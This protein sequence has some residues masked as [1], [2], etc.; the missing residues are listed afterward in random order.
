M[1]GVTAGTLSQRSLFDDSNPLH[2]FG[3]ACQRVLEV[4]LKAGEGL[5]DENLDEFR[6]I[7][8]RNHSSV[9]TS[10]YPID[11]EKVSVLALRLLQL[12]RPQ[13]P[14]SMPAD[15]VYGFLT[16]EDLRSD[17]CRR[18]F[19]IGS[20]SNEYSPDA[21]YIQ[22]SSS[23]VSGTRLPGFSDF[24]H[25]FLTQYAVIRGLNGIPLEELDGI[26]R[27]CIENN[28]VIP[29]R[30]WA[31]RLFKS[32]H[33][34]NTVDKVLKYLLQFEREVKTS[35]LE[36]M[37]GLFAVRP[38][39]FMDDFNWNISLSEKWFLGGQFLALSRGT[40]GD[41]LAGHPL[42]WHLFAILGCRS[43]VTLKWGHLYLLLLSRFQ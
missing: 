23:L 15:K 9:L 16:Q 4:Y 39:C 10:P 12:L 8:E 35:F 40:F 31:E 30:I 26:L 17:S 14:F 25:E 42:P 34:K 18:F 7:I 2:L 24:Q 20:I 21:I 11:V 36:E 1:E 32:P 33:P 28:E 5:S 6:K 13:I 22:F 41:V 19:D 43:L 29:F 3:P 27:I 37:K 38:R